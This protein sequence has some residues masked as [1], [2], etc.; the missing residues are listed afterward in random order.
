MELGDRV[1]AAERIMKKR[2]RRGGVEYLVKWKG[3]SQKHNTWEPEENILDGR[4]IDLYERS[5]KSDSTPHKRGPKKKEKHPEQT[6][7]VET[8]DEGHISGEESQDEAPLKPSKAAAP[9]PDT[10]PV[11]EDENA[12]ASASVTEEVKVEIAPLQTEI[13]PENSSSSSSEDR[14]ILSRR[15]AAGT[16]RKAEVLSKES[17]KIGV[18]ITTSSP[19]SSSPPPPKTPKLASPKSPVIPSPPPQTRVNGRRNSTVKVDEEP[20]VE[21]TVSV[22]PVSEPVKEEVKEVPVETVATKAKHSVDEVTVSKAEVKETSEKRT[23]QSSTSDPVECPQKR[24]VSSDTNK[25][26]NNVNSGKQ[27]LVNG[28]NNNNNNSSAISDT[29]PVLTSPGSDYWLARNPVVDQE[30][31]ASDEQSKSGDIV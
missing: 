16:K 29:T 9:K 11:P 10:P 25:I 19:V 12:R 18:T 8:E 21:T 14:P 6:V 30:R 4:L 31:S 22:P 1:Y 23:D 5:Q 28:H 20:V 13:D 2:I 27:C 7:Q 26:S 17:G 3:W 24:R 15:D